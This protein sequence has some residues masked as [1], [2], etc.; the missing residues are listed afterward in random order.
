MSKKWEAVHTGSAG[1]LDLLLLPF[2][3]RG[4]LQKW[5]AVQFNRQPLILNRLI[6]K[7]RTRLLNLIA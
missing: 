7:E 1:P 2:R 5:E 6:Y 4:P 3:K